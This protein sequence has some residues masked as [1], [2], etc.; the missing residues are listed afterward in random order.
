ME[1]ITKWNFITSS[2]KNKNENK[3]KLTASIL[4]Q[5]QNTQQFKK[6]SDFSRLYNTTLAQIVRVKPLFLAKDK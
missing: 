5:D 3:T 1:E 4:K 6:S 2:A